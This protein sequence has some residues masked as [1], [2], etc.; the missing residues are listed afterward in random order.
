MIKYLTWI[1]SI[2]PCGY[3]GAH[4][5][6]MQVFPSI[7]ASYALRSGNIDPKIAYSPINDLD[8]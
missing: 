2:T 6:S 5:Y 4:A 1:G 3:C 8:N 7:A